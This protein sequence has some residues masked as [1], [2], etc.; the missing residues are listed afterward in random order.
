MPAV[1]LSPTPFSCSPPIAGRATRQL[2]HRRTGGVIE[3]DR[4]STPPRC[5]NTC[6]ARGSALVPVGPTGV[7]ATSINEREL[8]YKCS[9]T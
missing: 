6:P 3:P 8:L 4:G 9:S 7:E 5:A 2:E 1:T